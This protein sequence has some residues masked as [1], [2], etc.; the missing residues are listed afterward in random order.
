MAAAN[1]AAWCDLVCR[2]HGIEGELHGAAWTSP[3][4]TPSL[5]P[6]AITLAPDVGVAE[7]LAR[8]DCSPGCSVKDS[9]ASLD[10]T[11]YGFQVLFD[12]Q[13][14]LRAPDVPIAATVEPQWTVVRDT[15]AFTAWERAWQRHDGSPA[16]LRPELLDDPAVR[17][18]AAEVDDRVV[19]GAVL[20]AGAD[21]VGLTNVFADDEIAAVSWAG[22]LALAARV[23]P[24]A[25]LVGYE[26]DDGLGTATRHGFEPIGPLRVWRRDPTPW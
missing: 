6:D 10:L 1:N 9:F 25:R 23:F 14:V 20:N 26:T 19:G 17:V 4:R 7:V 15:D 18:L 11:P 24:G 2:T 16:I 13:W 5:Y 3:T 12:A 8:V 21:V 22:C